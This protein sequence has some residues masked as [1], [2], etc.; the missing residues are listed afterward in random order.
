MLD[1]SSEQ[2]SNGNDTLQ[3]SVDALLKFGQQ[4]FLP[5]ALELL[6]LTRNKPRLSEDEILLLTITAAQAMRAHYTESGD[7][8][9]KETLK[10]ILRILDH[11]DVIRAEYKK[12]YAVLRAA[13]TIS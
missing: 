5:E 1:N 6:R 8:S 2:S 12:L 3:S 9:T 7:Q 13:A 11:E 10:V 4:Y